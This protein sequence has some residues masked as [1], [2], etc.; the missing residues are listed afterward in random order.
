[1]KG[2]VLRGIRQV[3]TWRQQWGIPPWVIS[4][5]VMALIVLVL[6]KTVPGAQGY[7][8]VGIALGVGFASLVF[9][10]IMEFKFP[11]RPGRPA[12]WVR[13]GIQQWERFRG[14]S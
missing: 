12:W 6:I 4:F 7:P 9:L 13:V 14:S 2:W 10:E 3:L 8:A 1:M 11:S 5:G